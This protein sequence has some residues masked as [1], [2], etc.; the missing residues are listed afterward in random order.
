MK[1][2]ERKWVIGSL[3]KDSQDNVR[4]LEHV[5]G[6]SLEHHIIE[7]A[8]IC[9]TRER[10]IRVRREEIY[11]I[12]DI[13]DH[14]QYDMYI[15]ELEGVDDTLVRKEDQ[16]SITNSTFEFACRHRIG[17]II[18]KERYEW[19]YN[20]LRIFVDFFKG[21]LD[22]LIMMEVEH[23]SIHA[24]NNYELEDFLPTG[25]AYMEVTAL[26]VFRNAN[27]ATMHTEYENNKLK[28]I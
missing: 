1:E 26:P 10:D 28:L 8:Y 21:E 11:D 7:Q 5:K 25:T 2:I 6:Q 20:G 17:N 13:Y 23:E 9:N 19:T 4:L 15:K 18:K 14:T 3:E 22:G 24:H 12:K 16:V 27:L